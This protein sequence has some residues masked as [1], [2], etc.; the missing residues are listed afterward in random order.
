M[1]LTALALTLKRQAR[2]DF[3]GRH[4][5]ATLIVQ[6]VSWSLRDALSDRDIEEML[7]ERDLTVDH[8]TI[9]RWVL[10]YRARLAVPAAGIRAVWCRYSFCIDSR[11]QKFI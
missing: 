1:I 11:Y 7:L 4:F 8:S 10:A 3:K 5:E 2:G 9:N 6:A